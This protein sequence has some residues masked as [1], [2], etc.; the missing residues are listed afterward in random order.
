MGDATHTTSA[1]AARL[2]LGVA[3]AAVGLGLAGWAGWHWT[4]S[5][6]EPPKDLRPALEKHFPKTPIDE[7]RCDVGPKGLCEVVTGRNVFYAV[8]GGRYV[9]VGAL[10]DLVDKVDLTDKRI[11]ELAA[12]T[13]STSKI[14]SG[15]NTSAQAPQPDPE[16]GVLRVDLGR[17]SAIVHNPGAPL[18][19][20]VFS[21]LNCGYCRQLFQELKDARDIE[22][23]EYP[24][25]ILG[26]DSAKKARIALCATDRAK[27]ANALYFG[28][29]VEVP[30]DCAEGE[31]RLAA[32]MAFAQANGIAGTPALVRG[33]GAVNRGW[34]ALVDLRAWLK[35]AR[36]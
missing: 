33:D 5:A 4:A 28:G 14:T 25:A 27:A 36:S 32:N 19:L 22:V 30:A 35:G 2:M 10:L 31:R 23:V 1:P 8:P 17:D 34:M 24:I 9:I 13:S 16:P 12:L 20:T 3:A 21:D 6:G 29:D 26:A 18:K 15:A 7:V 11:R